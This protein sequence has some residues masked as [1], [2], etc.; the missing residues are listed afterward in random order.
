M[1]KLVSNRTASCLH[2]RLARAP[3]N[4]A[5]E[6]AVSK[7]F[8]HSSVI[9]FKTFSTGFPCLFLCRWCA[10]KSDGRSIAIALISAGVSAI[11]VP[12]V[13]SK[14]SSADS[15]ADS[16]GEFNLLWF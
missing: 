15:S 1:L 2:I 9:Q 7:G 12:F 10:D 5:E 6:W 13:L 16:H 4:L 8:A 3:V 14:L 11:A